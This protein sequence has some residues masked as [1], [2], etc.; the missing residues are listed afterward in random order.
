MQEPCVDWGSIGVDGSTLMES[1]KT[2]WLQLREEHQE[3][4]TAKPAPFK[5]RSGSGP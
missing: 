2:Y 5:E 3:K 1:P 4:M